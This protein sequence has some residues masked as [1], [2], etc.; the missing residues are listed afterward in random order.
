[1]LFVYIHKILILLV[2]IHVKAYYNGGSYL[3]RVR[4]LVVVFRGLSPIQLV[5]ELTS[6]WT[7][8]GFD[9]V[10]HWCLVEL[11]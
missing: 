1:M 9:I 2:C 4:L 8:M 3:K 5:T 10:Q 7:E 6:D 11:R